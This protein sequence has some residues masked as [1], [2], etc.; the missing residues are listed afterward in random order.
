VVLAG[1][2]REKFLLEMLAIGCWWVARSRSPKVAVVASA[3][4][5]SP[6]SLK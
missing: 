6:Q 5:T 4:R 3:T 2:E 1:D